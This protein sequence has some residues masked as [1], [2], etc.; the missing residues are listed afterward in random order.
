[1]SSTPD[2]TTVLRARVAEAL[3]SVHVAV[4]GVVVTYDSARQRADVQPA[5]KRGYVDEEGDRQ[6]E[7]L[8]VVTSCPVVFPGSG[9]FA[10]TFPIAPG[11]EG[12]IVFASASLD[13]WLARGGVVDPEDDRRHHLT[14]GVF[15][16]GLRHGPLSPTAASPAAAV[17]AAPQVQLGGNTAVDAVLKGTSYLLVEV[18]LFAALAAMAAALATDPG[19]QA[20]SKSAAGAVAAVATAY[21][22]ALATVISTKV[23]TE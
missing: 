19:L 9:S 14:D 3:D 20:S 23:M 2:F 7:T 12:L 1:M 17:V 22:A 21:Q 5:V 15:L 16:P 18:P 11:D 4:P 10:I 13:R 8:P 6:V